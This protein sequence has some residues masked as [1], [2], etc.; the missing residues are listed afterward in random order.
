MAEEASQRDGSTRWIET[1][2]GILSYSQLAR[3]LAER[4]LTVQ[5]SI[6]ADCYSQNDLNE[7]LLLRIHGDFCGDLV[8]DWAGKWRNINVR[9]G[10]HEPPP[11]QQVPIEMRNYVEDLRERISHLQKLELL[12]AALAF[13]EGRLLSIHPFA[14]F[15][16]RAARLWLWEILR[17]LRLPPV[18]LA[19]LDATTQ[20]KYL[21][22]LRAAD[23]RNYEPLAELWRTRLADAGR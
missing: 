12:P 18:A 3:L 6:E 11:P 9:V 13:A 4:V 1:T 20:P 2:R 7:N 21:E 16:G 15:N 8:P 14:D 22:V 10:T 17:R 5:R 19:P 23:R